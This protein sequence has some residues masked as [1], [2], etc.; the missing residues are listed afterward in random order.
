MDVGSMD[1]IAKQFEDWV[2]R[3]VPHGNDAGTPR[4]P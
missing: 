4:S 3:F 1:G 2:D